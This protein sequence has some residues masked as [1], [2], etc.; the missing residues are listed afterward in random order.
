MRLA[1]DNPGDYDRRT[2]GEF[3]NK[4]QVSAHGLDGLPQR[5][6][7]KIAALFEARNAVLGDTESLGDPDLREL[8]R[9]PEFPQSHFLGN[10][11]GGSGLDLLALGGAQLPDDAIH[12]RRH[13]YFL[14]SLS[15]AR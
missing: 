4:G 9:V 12:V 8:A 13:D 11:L 3:S 10:Q 6:E 5:R 15:R 2:V 14:S 1:A 7:Q